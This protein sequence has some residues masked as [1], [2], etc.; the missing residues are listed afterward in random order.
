MRQGT[1]D[2]AADGVFTDACLAQDSLT[3]MNELITKHVRRFA[4]NIW[5]WKCLT[6]GK[7]SPGQGHV[8][9]AGVA[10]AGAEEEP[11]GASANMEADRGFAGKAGCMT[12][13]AS[14]TRARVRTVVIAAGVCVT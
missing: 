10:T 2:R 6:T 9:A 12:D 8:L 4:D 14:V 13:V 5:E 1:G 7:S 11:Y 3:G